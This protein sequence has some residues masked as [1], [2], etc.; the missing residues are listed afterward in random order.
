MKWEGRK[1][2]KEGPFEDA[3]H[4]GSDV[5]LNVRRGREEEREER[6]EGTW[7][8]NIKDITDKGE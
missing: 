5:K 2:R 8:K 4:G 7:F 3:R 1:G 6:E